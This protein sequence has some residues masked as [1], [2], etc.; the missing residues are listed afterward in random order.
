MRI[1]LNQLRRLCSF[2]LAFTIL[3]SS[4]VYAETWR[5]HLPQAKMLGGGEFRWW[6]F[7]IYTAKLWQQT[8]NKDGGLDPGAT[9]ALEITYSKS[10]S[11][12]RFVD[13]S[14]DEIKRLHENKYSAEK[15]LTW[16]QYMEKAF[17]D[18]K[19]GDQLIGVFLPGVGCRFYSQ[20]KLL[21]EIPD[22]AFAN[23]FFSIWLDPRTKDTNLRQQLLG[24]NKSTAIGAPT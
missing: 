3:L 13:S 23:A 4:S 5:Q 10:I 19:S 6:G 9:F 16:R 15:L 7:S 2:S 11:R 8:P 24:P 14:I 18:V 1:S 17:I 20:Q 21:A 12:E 22:E